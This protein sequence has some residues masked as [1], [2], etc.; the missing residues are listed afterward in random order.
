MKR[1]FLKDISASAIQVIL[2][3]ALGLLVFILTS[4]FLSKPVYGEL[5]WSLA[6]LTF[7]TTILSLRLEQIIVRKVAAGDD[8]SKML[9]LFAGHTFFFGLLFYVSL[10]L[11]SLIFPS[12]FKQHDLLLVLAIS[13]L[14]SFFSS[15]FKQ[16]ANG[17]EH[18]SSLAVMS[19]ISN[20]V[21]AV[22]LLGIVLFAV[23]TI[24]QVLIIYIVS[25]VIELLISIYIVQY[26]LKI[27]IS[28]RWALKDYFV[29][30]YESL[31]QMGAVFLNA[32]VAR[33][34]WILL[35]IFS[36]TIIT[37]EYSFAYKVFEL[38]PVPMLILGPVLLA[39]FSRYFS[40]HEEDDLVKRKKE[41]G[42]FIR[43][44]MIIATLLPLLLNIVWTP[45]IDAL[46]N[47]KYGA[48][49]KNTFLLLSF[50]IPFQY[51]INLLWTIQFA[52]NRLKLI[53][54]ITAVSCIIIICGD[55]FMIPLLN[56]T[57]AAIIYLLATATEYILYLRSSILRKIRESWQALFICIG[58]A[59]LSGFSVAYAG[60]GLFIKLFLATVIYV[61]LLLIT[62]Q[63]KKE[64]WL[65][66]R[67]WIVSKRST[68]FKE[69]P[70]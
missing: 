58:I 60:D 47:N 43:Y 3:Q 26:R 33:L 62:K 54:R 15:P 24:Q 49:N 12:F 32:C 10:F 6:I 67:D 16:L 2:N 48:V 66:I 20:L 13:Q 27:T 8:G 41:L 1:K 18:F 23:L 28:S 31:P 39:R 65:I 53:F 5:N 56:A 59:V 21:R 51:M 70:V 29:L 34:D 63:I 44:A 37:A 7:V 14:V 69:L 38:C 22:W 17:K 11:G 9:T 35:G 55:L 30:L 25:A 4:R 42:F 40:T 52:Q 36:T 50:C 46:T 19:S 61:V 57:G 45:M 64:D 68:S